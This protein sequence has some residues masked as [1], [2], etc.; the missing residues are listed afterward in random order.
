MLAKERMYDSACVGRAAGPRHRGEAIEEDRGRSP[1]E[2]TSCGGLR[3]RVPLVGE[4]WEGE[5]G[6]LAV[7]IGY[8]GSGGST[9]W[10]RSAGT[11]GKRPVRVGVQNPT[12]GTR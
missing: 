8:G 3:Y 2:L 10:D 9:E 7:G 4:G 5:D 6:P 11:I 1:G 12:G